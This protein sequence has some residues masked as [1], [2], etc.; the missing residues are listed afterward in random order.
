MSAG[1]LTAMTGITNLLAQ[2]ERKLRRMTIMLIRP[3]FLSYSIHNGAQHKIT[4]CSF[5]QSNLSSRL[6]IYSN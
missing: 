6:I 3:A 4:L 2:K 5:F 1:K